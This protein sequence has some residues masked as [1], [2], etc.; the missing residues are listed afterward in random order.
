ML[1]LQSA[2]TGIIVGHGAQDNFLQAFP[3]K[4][5]SPGQLAPWTDES[6]ACSA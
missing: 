6:H 4:E 5:G 2:E 1:P 3:A